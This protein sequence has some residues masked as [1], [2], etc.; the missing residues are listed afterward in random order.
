MIDQPIHVTDAEF[1]QK[2][3]QST[4][5]V[6]VDFWAPWC[7]PC[8]MVAPILDKLA[9]EF[10]GKIVVAKVNT[11]ENPEWATRFGVQGIPTM[12]FVYSGKVVHTQVGALPEGIL[13]NVVEQF[14]DFSSKNVP[15]AE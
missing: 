9:R 10:S 14:L 11:D 13:R 1:E 12:L 3:L 6:I 8:R 7:G 15:A 4:L 2:V 5:P